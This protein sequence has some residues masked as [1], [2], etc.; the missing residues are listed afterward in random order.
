[1]LLKNRRAAYIALSTRDDEKQGDTS[2]ERTAA[3]KAR[4]RELVRITGVRQGGNREKHF[5]CIFD[6]S[7]SD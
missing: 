2:E 6:S 5:I 1:M 7:L 4:Q 3:K